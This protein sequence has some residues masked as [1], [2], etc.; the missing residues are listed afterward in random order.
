MKSRSWV[1]VLFG[2]PEDVD[3]LLGG[4]PDHRGAEDL[5][6][7]LIHD[8]CR[9]GLG[10]GISPRRE[11]IFH[12]AHRDLGVEAFLLGL[13]FGQPDARQR[14]HGVDGGGKARIVRLVLRPLDDVGADDAT[15][16]GGD[17]RKLGRARQHVAA[18]VDSRVRG[19]AQIRID[20]DSEVVMA[21]A[22]GVEVEMIDIGDAAGA[23]DH[24]V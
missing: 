3:Q 1:A 17:G 23:I 20:G 16:I 6:A 9:P 22:T 8:H 12:V 13:R 21:D 2:E 18:G 5:V 4:V 11:P 19:R 24:A 14:R 7:R 10:L 15:L